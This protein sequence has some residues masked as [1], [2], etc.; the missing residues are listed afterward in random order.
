MELVNYTT[1][2]DTKA[3]RVK[4]TVKNNLLLTAI[5]Q[6]GY[7][8]VAEF[9]RDIGL[10]AQEISSFVALRKAPIN[11]DG[12]FCP[13]AKKIM[14]ALGAAPSDLWTTE[15]LNMK[16]KR[17]TTQDL[18]SAPTI[19]AILGGN[20]AQLEGSVYEESEKPEEVLNKKELKAELE[21]VLGTLTP[22]E[23]KVLQLRFG[24]D[25]CEE[26]TLGEVGDMLNIGKE[27][28]RQIEAKALRNMRHPSRSTIFREY[29]D[30]LMSADTYKPVWMTEELEDENSRDD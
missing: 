4:I 14:E 28:V 12:E 26:H 3:Y 17:N 29:A 25:G 15:Q 10:T 2:E 11:Q 18:F 13:N 16:L 19:Q 7:K 8:S 9:S 20:V 21:K 6:V 30:D 23:A 5:E 1:P 27:R 24:L 22:R